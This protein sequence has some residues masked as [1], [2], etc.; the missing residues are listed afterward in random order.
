MQV[1][2]G[3][4]ARQIAMRNRTK[5]FAL[6][7]VRAC[8]IAAPTMAAR[9]ITG[10][11]IR[12]STSVAANYRAACRAKSRRD[13]ISKIGTVLEEADETQF[14]LEFARDLGLLTG[15]NIE[16][17]LSESNQLVAIFTATRSTAR[18]RLRKN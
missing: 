18:A 16:S 5:E 1:S 11:L 6:D 13:F 10:Q 9:H 2:D 8:N 4:L 17:I 14:W 7:V 12:S 3:A 15:G